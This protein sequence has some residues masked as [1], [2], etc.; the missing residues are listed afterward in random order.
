M[1]YGNVYLNY[2]IDWTAGLVWIAMGSMKRQKMVSC[3]WPLVEADYNTLLHSIHNTQ[4]VQY[5]VIEVL[6]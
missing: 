6:L 5:E 3:G 4:Y 1:K 2:C